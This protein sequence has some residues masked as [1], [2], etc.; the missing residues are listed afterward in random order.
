MMKRVVFNTPNWWNNSYIRVRD[1]WDKIT[2]TYKE[3]KSWDLDI[4]SIS[5]LETEV[6]NFDEMV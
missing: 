3:Q 5:E 4:T 1:E 6:W 2:T